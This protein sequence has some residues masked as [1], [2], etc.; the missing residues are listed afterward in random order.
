MTDSQLSPA[1]ITVGEELVWGELA[2]G[3]QQ[4]MLQWLKE[5]DQPAGIAMTLPDHQDTIAKW[6]R[7]LHKEFCP[8]IVSGGIGGTHDDCTRQAI[9]QSLGIPIIRHP[10]CY[11]ILVKRYQDRLNEARARMADLPEGCALIANPEGA[12]G[13]HVQRIFAFPGFPSMLK[14]MLPMTLPTW[15]RDSSEW[16]IQEIILDVPEGDAAEA[17]EN[18]SNQWPNARLGIY[19]HSLQ[20]APRR[21][22]LRL[23]YPANATAV[24]QAFEELVQQLRLTIPL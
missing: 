5:Q 9:A 4:W 8:L 7:E 22:T 12:P 11:S 10:E 3:N 19:A 17:V 6:L 23:R 24:Q 18:F 15:K 13:F 20:E 1:V 2:N 21:V 16:K 14:A